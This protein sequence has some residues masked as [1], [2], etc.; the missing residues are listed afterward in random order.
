MLPCRQG[1]EE[2]RGGTDTEKSLTEIERHKIG[3]LGLL[4]G[5]KLKF[6]WRPISLEKNM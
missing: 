5:S 6:G 4:H 3:G 2:K 1:L